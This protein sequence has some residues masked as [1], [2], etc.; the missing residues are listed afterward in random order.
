MADI[1]RRE[2]KD[3]HFKRYKF[4][5]NV[6]IGENSEQGFCIAS[7]AVWDKQNDNYLCVEYNNGNLAAIVVVHG[8]YF[9]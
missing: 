9:E 1:I 2:I 6:Y 7:R 4:I 5:V 8:V 3:L